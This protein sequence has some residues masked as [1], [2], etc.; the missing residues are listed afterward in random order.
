MTHHRVLSSHRISLAIYHTGNTWQ[1]TGDCDADASIIDRTGSPTQR[2]PHMADDQHGYKVGPA[3]PP[4]HTRFR[5]GQSG[6]P[7]GCSKKK[8][9]APLANALPPP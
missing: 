7:G 8:L 4:L 5:K 1:K 6:N 9:H 2:S 3:R